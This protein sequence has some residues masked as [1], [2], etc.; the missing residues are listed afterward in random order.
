MSGLVCPTCIEAGTEREF[1][2]KDVEA[3]VRTFEAETLDSFAEGRGEFEERRE[4][5]GW[6]LVPCGHEYPVGDWVV[7][8]DEYGLRLH[9]RSRVMLI[10]DNGEV[11]P[12]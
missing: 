2:V 6:R 7:I 4:V 3:Q 8:V 9:K 10:A 1:P 12:A 11:T 5:T